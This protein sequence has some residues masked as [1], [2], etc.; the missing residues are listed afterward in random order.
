MKRTLF[1]LFALLIVLSLALTACGGG[2][3]PA[4]EAPVAEAP[5]VNE[6]PAAATEA[7]VAAAEE[8]TVTIGFTASQTGA[9]EVSSKRQV[10]GFNLWMDQVN[11]AGDSP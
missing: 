6:E 8:V 3:A 2:A 11:E 5:A 1:N 10:N 4:T 9:Q 7:P